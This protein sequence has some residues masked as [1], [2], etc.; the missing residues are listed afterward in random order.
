MTIR[1]GLFMKA[2]MMAIFWRMPREYSFILR[3]GLISN[4][5]ASAIAASAS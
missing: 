4:R 1:S 2:W 5:R 3:S